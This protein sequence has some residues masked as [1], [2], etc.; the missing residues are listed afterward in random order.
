[1]DQAKLRSFLW[2]LGH[3]KKSSGGSLFGCPL[4]REKIGTEKMPASGTMR[5]VRGRRSSPPLPLPFPLQVFL[6]PTLVSLSPAKSAG[7]GPQ[8]YSLSPLLL[9]FLL[10]LL[11][12]PSLLFLPLFYSFLSFLLSSFS[13]PCLSF[14]CT[15]SSCW[16]DAFFQFFRLRSRLFRL[17]T[18]LTSLGFFTASPF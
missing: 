15:R 18:C 4:S 1:M 14:F 16:P 13:S 3:R 10:P 2:R 5:G 9:L 17:R 8:P 7:Y 6:C 12:H 11:L